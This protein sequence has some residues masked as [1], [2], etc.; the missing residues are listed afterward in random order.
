MNS[1][2]SQAKIVE[3]IVL[4]S[5]IL[6]NIADVYLR[7]FDYTQAINFYKESLIQNGKSGNEVISSFISLKLA[8][9]QYLKGL[10]EEDKELLDE[11]KDSFEDIAADFE[12]I[13]SIL[14]IPITRP[15]D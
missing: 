12:K 1:A 3:D 11:A 9:A 6:N 13:S 10:L 2:L 8:S 5:V 15:P 7:Q 14:P 4:E